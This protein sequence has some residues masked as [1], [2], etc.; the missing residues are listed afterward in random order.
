MFLRAGGSHRARVRS[1]TMSA[2]SDCQPP[3]AAW[4]ATWFR[5]SL[6]A[7]VWAGIYLPALGSLQLDHEEPRRALPAVHMLSRGDWLVPR[8][9]SEPYL[10]KPP[11]LNWL[12]AVS[13]AAFGRTEASAR[14]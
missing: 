2:E 9:G 11:L 13:F 3:A 14:L 4:A 7:L 12:I 6:I 8:V 1:A 10:R 5:C